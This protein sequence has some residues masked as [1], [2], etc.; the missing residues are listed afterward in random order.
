VSAAGLQLI[1]LSGFLESALCVLLFVMYGVTGDVLNAMASARAA[2]RERWRRFIYGALKFDVF[3][4]MAPSLPLTAQGQRRSPRT[5]WRCCTR[6]MAQAFFRTGGGASRRTRPARLVFEKAPTLTCAGS[7][8]VS[9]LVAEG[10]ASS[11]GDAVELGRKMVALGMIAHAT[12]EH[13]FKD[14]HFFYNLD[15]TLRCAD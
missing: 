9:W 6:R 1:L 7:E 10:G 12:C 8:L 5:W 2:A 15:V 14:E 4:S 13:N 11:R 3:P